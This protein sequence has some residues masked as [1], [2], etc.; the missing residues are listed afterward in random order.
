MGTIT[1]LLPSIA[2]DILI[3]SNEDEI[4][5]KIKQLNESVLTIETDYSK[6]DLTIKWEKVRQIVSKRHFSIFLSDREKIFGSFNTSGKPSHTILENEGAFIKEVDMNDI[7]LI[8][9]IKESFQ[10]QFT[11]SIS[12]GLTVTKANNSRQFSTRATFGYTKRDW[13]LRGTFNDV[14]N[15]QDNTEDV[16]RTDASLDFSYLFYNNWFAA[17][18]NDFLS[19]TEQQLNFRSTNTL[20]IGNLVVRTNKMYLSASTGLTYNRE[21]FEN[22]SAVNNSSEYFL[23]A[24][25]NAYDIGDLSLLTKL[26]YFPSLTESGRQRVNFSADIKYDFPLDFFIKFGYT[27]NFDSRPPNEGAKDDYVFVTTVGWEF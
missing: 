12:A 16:S 8:D 23:G 26:G 11:A 2:Q 7:V 3:L 24:T 5:G 14:D 27:L 25:F 20:A 1:P 4:H 6:S 15:R 18:N 13:D 22:E 19:N 10:D 9:P 21:Q 17:L